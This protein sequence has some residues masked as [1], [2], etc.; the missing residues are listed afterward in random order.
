M[1]LAKNAKCH[2]NENVVVLLVIEGHVV[3]PHAE[4]AEVVVPHRV[5]VRLSLLGGGRVSSLYEIFQICDWQNIYLSF[6]GENLIICLFFM[7]SLTQG[8]NLFFILS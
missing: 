1:N 6:L 3:V 4:E 2:I 5:R 8:C 7:H